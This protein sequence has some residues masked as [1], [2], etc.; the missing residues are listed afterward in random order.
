MIMIIKPSAM[1]RND[2]SLAKESEEPIYITKNGGAD[3]I[4]MSIEAF[5]RREQLSNLRASVFDAEEERLSGKPTMSIA[6]ARKALV[7]RRNGKM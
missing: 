5:G 4:F 3:G 7:Q 6:E 2:Y 1:L